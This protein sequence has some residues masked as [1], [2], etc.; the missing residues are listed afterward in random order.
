[1]A[2]NIVLLS[3]GTGN[4]SHDPF[5]T[6]VWRLYQALDLNRLQAEPGPP[7]QIACYDDGV[8]TESSQLWALP[9]L[10]FGYGLMQNV[11]DLYTFLCRNYEKGD[12]IYCFGFSRGAFTVRVLADLIT[13]QGLIPRQLP[14]GEEMT[15]ANLQRL[16]GAAFR[17]SRWKYGK[18]HKVMHALRNVLRHTRDG[19]IRVWD[20]I[21]KRPSYD[22]IERIPINELAFVGVWDTVAAY[23]LPVDELT[24]AW[25][26]VFP[27][28]FPDQNLSPK[29]KRACHALALDDERHSFHPELW[30][31]D[32]RKYP[33]SQSHLAAEAAAATE[34]TLHER[35]LQVW[36]A[37]MHSD[38]GGSYPDDAM[39][40]APLQWMLGHAEN[41]GL[42][43]K[44]LEKNNINAAANVYGPIHDS[45]SGTGGFYRYQPRKL[46]RLLH[47][48]DAKVEIKWPIIHESVFERIQQGTDGYAPIVLPAQYLVY[49]RQ[50]D[51][52]WQGQP[53]N[54]HLPD[55]W[56][57]NLATSTT[58]APAALS[59]LSETPDEA[60]LRAGRQEHVWNLVWIKRGVYFLTVTA[61]LALAAFPLFF[62]ANASCEGRFCFAAPAISLLGYVLPGMFAPLLAAYET[63][64][65]WFLLFFAA[66]LA[67]LWSG[68]TMERR[69]ADSM[70]KLWHDPR[71]EHA[72]TAK[73]SGG[74][75]GL[76]ESG[77]YQALVN[78]FRKVILPALAALFAVWVIAGCVSHFTVTV[79][80]SSGCVCAKSAQADEALQ[81]TTKKYDESVQEALSKYKLEVAK[82]ELT[83]ACPACGLTVNE[84]PV[85]LLPRLPSNFDGKNP[86]WPSGYWVEEGQRYKLFLNAVGPW[87]DASI[88]PDDM[89]GFEATEK[90]VPWP[91]KPAFYWAFW[92]RRHLSEPWFK[93]LARIGP[94][95]RDEYPLD[96]QGSATKNT[97]VAEFTARRDGEL[98]LFLN[99]ATLPAPARWQY[100]Y[101]NNQAIAEVRIQRLDAA[102]E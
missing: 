32:E 57:R 102:G 72:P 40:F 100:F 69:I 91:S 9:G 28:S 50:G 55:C 86:C 42:R 76:R 25:D 3:D 68:N 63:N 85:L 11:I 31:E 6:N 29:I 82:Y 62:P 44:L 73:P 64:P 27:L 36:F 84:P 22:S 80:E 17:A 92:F 5:K 33:G 71:A 21:L 95:G 38:V 18:Q 30:N 93:P 97:L 98:Y 24:R 70:H 49:S 15:E 59:T 8:G 34:N 89:D 74:I 96:P 12:R 41:A 7:D 66:F 101:N 90:V 4:S 47:D 14:T 19:F 26:F 75:F 1:M 78:A 16:A 99:D 58:A 23:G 88:V 43:F 87:Q 53:G 20:K 79:L 54:Q 60:A 77:W 10:A 67:L 2:K 52:H 51:I 37:G 65:G 56:Q 39:S 61:A 45:R 83:K 13:E 94:T 46:E 48:P 35:L 81:S